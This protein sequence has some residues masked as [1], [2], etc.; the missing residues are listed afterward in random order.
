[1]HAKHHV[2]PL[3]IGIL[4]GFLASSGLLQA[5]VAATP[6]TDPFTSLVNPGQASTA[7]PDLV[8]AVVLA[9]IALAG[10][11]ALRRRPDQLANDLFPPSPTSTT[12]DA[13]NRIPPERRELSTTTRRGK[14]YRVSPRR[15]APRSRRTSS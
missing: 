5:A 9:L 13:L 10:A 12:H 8:L 6:P 7:S 2:R 1:M 15:R 4:A 11:I 3:L 14:R